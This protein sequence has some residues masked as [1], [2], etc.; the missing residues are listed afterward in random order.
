MRWLD[1][2]SPASVTAVSNGL[3]EDSDFESLVAHI[4]SHINHYKYKDSVDIC[5]NIYVDFCRVIAPNGYKTK[6]LANDSPLREVIDIIKRFVS[7]KLCQFSETHHLVSYTV[8]SFLWM[9]KDE[10]KSFTFDKAFKDEIDQSELFRNRRSLL[11]WLIHE[12]QV[13]EV[14]TRVIHY[15]HRV[16][17]LYNHTTRDVIPSFVNVIH[18]IVAKLLYWCF[19]PVF[20][21]YTSKAVWAMI[22]A[23]FSKMNKVAKRFDVFDLESGFE[24]RKDH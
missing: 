19:L 5:A 11:N 3:F 10:V 23:D 24:N 12:P 15:I 18:F 17:S 2:R 14:V 9:T 20:E 7:D 1:N 16:W 22:K 13:T 4:D 21:D 8:G 6:S